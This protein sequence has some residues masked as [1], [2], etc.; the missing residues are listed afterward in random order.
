MKVQFSKIDAQECVSE[1]PI[2]VCL[3]DQSAELHTFQ[4]LLT[5]HC[6]LLFILLQHESGNNI[7][8]FFQIVPLQTA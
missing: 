4:I 8:K 7:L 2:L 1:Y 5:F 3:C 6:T